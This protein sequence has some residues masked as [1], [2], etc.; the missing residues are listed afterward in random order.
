[1]VISQSLKSLSCFA[2][3]FNVA[4]EVP[5]LVGCEGVEE[6]NH[7]GSIEAGRDG[8]KEVG[9]FV[10]AFKVG[11][12]EVSGFDGLL[13][14]ITETFRGR[15][16]SLTLCSV[17]AGACLG[18]EG[19]SLSDVVCVFCGVIKPGRLFR[20]RDGNSIVLFVPPAARETLDVGDDALKFSLVHFGKGRHGGSGD[21]F[22]DRSPQVI[23]GREFSVRRGAKFKNAAAKIAGFVGHGF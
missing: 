13:P 2:Q 11:P 19:F 18:K 15:P 20:K 21:S 4:N 1:M 17:A 22:P 10:A 12:G 7:W 14:N 5:D 23:I 9:R 6:A 3:A 8:S 16:V